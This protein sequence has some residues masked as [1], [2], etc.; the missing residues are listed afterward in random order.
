ML[1]KYTNGKAVAITAPVTT[2]AYRTSCN[3]QL[4]V[5]GDV[6]QADLHSTSPAATGSG[7]VHSAV[8][9]QARIMPGQYGGIGIEYHGGSPA[10]INQIGVVWKA[11]AVK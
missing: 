11:G 2:S 4:S 8:T 7:G 1:I 10:M 9:L 6:L 3:I 5:K